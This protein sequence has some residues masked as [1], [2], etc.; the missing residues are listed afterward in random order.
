M[1]KLFSLT[2]IQ[3]FCVAVLLVS[4]AVF[5]YSVSPVF[6]IS[7]PQYMSYQGQLFDG[8]DEPVSDTVSIEFTMYDAL[9]GG[10]EVWSETQTVVVDNGYF[11]VTLGSVNP[12]DIEWSDQYFITLNIDSDGEMTPRQPINTAAYAFTADLAY[13]TLAD[14]SAPVSSVTGSL[15]FDTAD[16]VLKVYDGSDWIVLVTSTV[17]GVGDVVA[18]ADNILTGDN[19]FTGSTLFATTTVSGP[20]LLGSYLQFTTNGNNHLYFDN[21]TSNRISWNDSLDKFEITNDL[22]VTGTVTSTAVVAGTG[23]IGA[24]T[25]TSTVSFPANS[26]TDA[27]IPNTIT[28]SN[29]LAIANN[30]SD[31]GNVAT[32]RTNLGLG[33]ASLLS[34]GAIL[35][36]ANNFSDIGNASTARTN[37]GLAIGTNVQAFDADLATFAALSPSGF[38]VGTGSAWVVQSTST[39][40]TSLGLGSIA[41]AASSD[42]LQVTNNL[43]DLANSSTARTNLGLGSIA[44][45]SAGSYLAVVNNLS[46]LTNSSTARTNLG[47]GSMATMASGDYL[48]LSSWYSTTTDALDEGSV[49]QYF[50]TERAR[51]SLSSGATGLSYATSTGIFSLTS[52]YTIPLSAST[53]DWQTAFGWGNH[54]TAGY[55]TTSTGLTVANFA[56]SD[57]SQWTNNAGYLTSLSGAL[58]GS[59][60]LSDLTNTGTARTNLG[61]GTIA[62]ASAGDYLTLSGGTLTGTLIGT[63]VSS[64]NG[65]FGTV[66][67]TVLVVNGST[68][69][70]FGGSINV[71]SGSC[72]SVDGVCLTSSG[73]SALQIANNLSDLAN[74]STA[75]TNLGFTGGTGISIAGNGAISLSSNNISQFTNDAGYITT[76]TNLTTDNFASANISQWTND[77]GYLTS[78]GAESDPVWSA[79]S[80]SYLTV[81]DAALTYLDLSSPDITNWNTA[82]GWGDHSIAGYLTSLTGA[83]LSSNNLSDLADTATAQLNLGLGSAA[84]LSSAAVLQSANDLSDLSSP[85]NARI[86]LGLGDVATLSTLD[87]FQPI[88]NLS[89]LIDPSLARTNLGLGSAATL[90]SSD[91]LQPMNDLSD[92][93]SAFNARFNLGLGDVATFSTFDVLQPSNNLSDLTDPSTARTNLGFSGG[94]GITLSGVGEIALSSTDISQFTNDSG[95]LTSLSGALLVANDLSDLADPASARTNLGLGTMATAASSDYLALA[96]GTMTGGLTFTTLTGTTV[97]STNATI[98]ALTVTSTVSLPNNSVTDAMIPDTITASNYLLLSGGTLTGTLIGT[99]VSSTNALFGTVTTTALSVTGTNTSTFGGSINLP[100]GYCFAVNGTCLTSGSGLTSP[101]ANDTFLEGYKADGVT[102]EEIIGVASD[103]SVVVGSYSQ[104]M[105][106][107]LISSDN[108]TF[109]TS[110]T[111]EGNSA[112]TFLGNLADDSFQQYLRQSAKLIEYTAS[113]ST[114]PLSGGITLDFKSLSGAST[115]GSKLLV[116]G[117]YGLSDLGNEV[118]YLTEQTETTEVGDGAETGY[119]YWTIKYDGSDYQPMSLFAGRLRTCLLYTSDAADDM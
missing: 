96:G 57:I 90:S 30:L 45:A 13:R 6:A 71:P 75:R 14:S 78:A 62:T 73:G 77:A 105:P 106:V 12:L 109:S 107:R 1:T 60:N 81:A 88:N 99:T 56:S 20:A 39:F 7:V 52:G 86:S 72:F 47:L 37:L 15:Y 34:S 101:M 113:N 27:M 89:E 92:I 18:A 94:T 29:Y 16:S 48:S 103:D 33:S 11:A 79:A 46:D 3:S 64:T 55:L 35:Q 26:I 67:T 83:L 9:S 32:A 68:T 110:L 85:S 17:P 93:S 4:I 31:I 2:K 49:N 119:S 40:R 19:E 98:G 84:T 80:S 69:S 24:L 61:L 117:V 51:A 5:A 114:D 43:S 25:V 23:T 65:L 118:T 63:T 76:S 22:D 115:N 91:F 59:N 100:T 70:S 38:L 36:S 44:T 58:L 74:T 82:Y 104:G 87:I 95:Y 54:A 41:T 53:T 10:A 66:T 116:K 50:T 111:V 42:Y 102:A 8:T 97:T 21:G 28:A 112:T 108:T